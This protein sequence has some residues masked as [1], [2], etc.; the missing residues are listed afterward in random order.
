VKRNSSSVERFLDLLK[1][2]KRGKF[3]IYIGMAAGVGKSYRMLQEAHSLLKNG[4][5]IW[6]GYIETH[7]R[8]ETE[9][10]IK[11]LPIIPRKQIFYKG[12]SLEEIDVEAII[13]K[14]PE[15]VIVDELAH[16]NV[17]GSKNEKRWQDVEEILNAGIS[18][19]SAVNIQHIE[20]INAEVKKI[21]GI[22]VKERVPDSVIRMADEVVNI[23]LT[24]DELVQRLME[25]KIYTPDKVNTALTNFFKK[26]NLL[27]LRELALKEVTHQVERKVD[28]EIPSNIKLSDNILACIGTNDKITKRVIRKT[29]RFA[30]RFNAQWFV[31]YIETHQSSLSAIDLATQRHL[32][33][34]FQMAT[35]MGGILQRIKGND[36]AEEI[37]KF[38]REN[39][40]SVI[41]IGRSKGKWYQ[42]I[43]RQDIISKLQRILKNSNIDLLIVT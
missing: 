32:I 34:N 8:I 36:A 24:I 5:D 7:N 19:I 23:D 15:V 14:Q 35:E 2:S 4:V 42:K 11:G 43:F 27:Q 17:P 12:H 13:L 30:G 31:L 3:K 37:A 20:S 22:E 41:V 16:A 26:D 28:I 33:N 29:A 18:V 39:N 40:I 38:S 10:L 25:G 21:T 6:I 1:N 9:A